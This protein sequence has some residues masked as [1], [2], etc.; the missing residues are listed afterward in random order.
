MPQRNQAGRGYRILLATIVIAAFM[1]FPAMAETESN[2]SDTGT[3]SAAATET[4]PAIAP[5]ENTSVSAGIPADNGTVGPDNPLYGLKLTFENLDE[6]FTPDPAARLDKQVQH[7]GLR[8]SEAKWQMQRNQSGPAALALEQYYAKINLTENTVAELPANATGLLRA[9][10][11]IAQHQYVLEDLLASHGNTTG[12]RQAYENSVRLGLRFENKTNQAIERKV[13][14][15]RIELVP[16]PVGNE[17]RTRAET[18]FGPG[19]GN[20]VQVREENENRTQVSKGTPGVVPS[21]GRN[22]SSGSQDT[23]KNMDNGNGTGSGNGRNQPAINPAGTT[24]GQNTGQGT[25]QAQRETPAKV[26]RTGTPGT[27][28]GQPGNGNDNQQGNSNKK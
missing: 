24:Q 15:G 17:T 12:L 6:S 7:A 16:V 2:T 21:A 4:L 5:A 18:G 25:G 3:V 19:T 9:Q 26:S 23:G 28:N 10:E 13:S 1:I 8:L 11:R 22:A 14:A 20:S 27:A